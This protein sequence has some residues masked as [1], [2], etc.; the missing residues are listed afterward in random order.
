MDENASGVSVEFHLFD[1]EY[2]RKLAD[3]DPSTES[4]FSAYFG[5]FILAKL[6]ARKVAV[7]MAEDIRQETLLRVLKSL[8]QG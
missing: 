1:S 7:E 6:R 3:A 8:R 4:H 2:V 5:T